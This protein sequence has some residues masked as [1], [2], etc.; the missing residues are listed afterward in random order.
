M[1]QSGW[2]RIWVV[3]VVLFELFI[4]ANL[5]SIKLAFNNA[6]HYADFQLKE[7]AELQQIGIVGLFVWPLV[8][9]IIFF[10][11]RWITRGFSGHD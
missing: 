2:A 7:M 4:V 6:D 3:L 1:L 10:A 9:A 5:V 11:A 8:A